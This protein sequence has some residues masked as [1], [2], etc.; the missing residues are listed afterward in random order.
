ME[1]RKPTQAAFYGR[2]HTKWAKEKFKYIK[3]NLLY[4][5]SVV[6][7]A[8]VL[9]FGVY[10]ISYYTPDSSYPNAWLTQTSGGLLTGLYT[11]Y[12]FLIIASL[13][14][15]SNN[16][17]LDNLHKD[18][19]RMKNE[20]KY[21]RMIDFVKNGDQY[22]VLLENHYDS[23]GQHLYYN[24]IPA[25]DSKGV[26]LYDYDGI[27][28]VYIVRVDSISY[29]DELEE[30]LNLDYLQ[31]P[32][33]PGE[34]YFVKFIN[35]KWGFQA[36]DFEH[37]P[38]LW[39][40]KS[41]G[42]RNVPSANKIA[43]TNMELDTC[44]TFIYDIES[45]NISNSGCMATVSRSK[46][47]DLYVFPRRDSAPKKIFVT[48]K[49]GDYSKEHSFIKIENIYGYFHSLEA[50]ENFK[51]VIK[52]KLKEEQIPLPVLDWWEGKKIPGL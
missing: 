12:I 1:T 32:I 28:N 30:K 50:L 21:Q 15:H 5:A 9:P 29:K 16:R 22:D 27:E 41:T 2:R 7:F 44:T 17:K 52:T 23:E 19:E 6:F 48:F 39:A 49:D 25:R 45:G 31:S 13:F 20:R 10:L 43:S 3:S 26:P 46:T 42:C 18:L 47:G 37:V 24:I 4:L 35:N 8:L 40:G 38:F 11:G 51:S 36:E 14:Q 33:S 34:Y